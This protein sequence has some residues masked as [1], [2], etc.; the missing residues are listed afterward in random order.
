MTASG[1]KSDPS[2]ADLLCEMGCK[3]S[4]YLREL[5]LN[6]PATRQ[7]VLLTEHRRGIVDEQTALSN[8]LT[9]AL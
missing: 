1:A 8:Q 2:D 5:E 6:D 4:K 7:L 9:S 3:H